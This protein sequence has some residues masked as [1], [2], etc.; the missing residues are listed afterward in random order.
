MGDLARATKNVVCGPSNMNVAEVKKKNLHRL[1]TVSL[2]IGVSQ[3]QSYDVEILRR[4]TAGYSQASSA[5]MENFPIEVMH[6]STSAIN[7][8]KKRQADAARATEEAAAAR[9]ALATPS[10][11]DRVVKTRLVAHSS[12]S[13]VVR[14]TKPWCRLAGQ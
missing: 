1:S 8:I 13:A 9:Q 2:G 3:R 12:R 10:H 6:R 4:D 11:N 5:I 7:L 14:G